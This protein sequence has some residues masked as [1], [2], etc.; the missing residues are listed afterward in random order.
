[1]GA[2]VA[3]VVGLVLMGVGIAGAAGDWGSTTKVSAAASAAPSTSTSAPS[4]SAPSTSAPSP[5]TSAF[6]PAESPEDLPALLNQAITDGDTELLLA[7]L[8]PAVIA[9]YGA[10][11]CRG[12]VSRF[13]S[14]FTVL[15]EATTPADYSYTTEGQT[16]VVPDTIALPVRVSG[17]GSPPS[18]ALMHIADADGTLRFFT[19]CTPPPSG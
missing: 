4:T 9:R 7:R 19:D 5:S 2:I 16:T 15:G 6:V 3:L 18:D 17:P 1:V 14:Q 8:H 12:H 11:V 10:E 13:T